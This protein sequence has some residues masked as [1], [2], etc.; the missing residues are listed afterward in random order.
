M[1]NLLIVVA[2]A[3]V[4]AISGCSED[5]ASSTPQADKSAAGK[6]AKGE[7]KKRAHLVEVA[8]AVIDSLRITS[9][10]TGSLR[11]RRTVR[12]FS[13]EEGRIV[14]LPFFEG[15]HV[16]EGQVIL[17]IDDALLQAEL[18]KARAVRREAETN[19]ARLKRLRDSRMVSEDEYLRA[20]TAL[21]VAKAEEAVLQ[22]RLGYT[23]VRAPFAGVIATR[24]A[25]P[26]DIVERHTHV[27]TLI[28]PTRL[29]TDL[30]VS[31]L[32]I[33]H[34]AINDTV[35]LR[36]DALGDRVFKGVI[37]RIHPEV[38]ARTRQGRVEVALQPVPDG[39]RPGQFARVTFTV[40]ALDRKV[41]PF[42]A[43]RRDNDGEFIFL[44]GSDNR[45][46][47]VPV[48]SGRRLADRVE[49]LSGVEAGDRVVVKGFLGLVEG[50]EVKPV[51][52]KKRTE[53]A[54]G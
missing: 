50:M 9:V 19:I 42:S 26:G 36:I 6:G 48:Q 2:M 12:V 27:L 29:L 39:A 51:G 15:D 35:S 16:D 17:E 54:T 24:L 21:E 45:V 47:R 28:D 37:L 44:M 8:P 46:K 7:G 13:Q 14:S 23:R 30:D 31:E 53:P 33:P 4:M 3:A 25:E 49:I 22:T 32:L 1:R 10:Y 52:G 20:A 5:A 18:D 11:S 41:L 43:L 34:L 38:D 40:E